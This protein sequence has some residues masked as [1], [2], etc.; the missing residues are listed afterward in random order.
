MSSMP[1]KP[2]T[3]PVARTLAEK[4]SAPTTSTHFRRSM[5]AAM[6]ANGTTSA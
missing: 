3:K 1:T 4:D 2:P 5:S 6:P